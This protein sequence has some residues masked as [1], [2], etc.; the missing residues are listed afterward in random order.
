MALPEKLKRFRPDTLT[1]ILIA[2]IIYIWFRPPAWVKDFNSPAPTFAVS[3]LDGREVT[4]E[5]LKGK[6]VLVSFW[7]TW[8]PYCRHEMPS[9]DEFYQDY[10]NKGFEILALSIDDEPDKVQAF[11][12]ETGYHFPVGMSDPLIS[13]A[14]GGV[15]QVPMSFVIDTEGRIRHKVTGQVHYAR[16]E[17]LVGPLLPKN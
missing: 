17:S 15:S 2:V 12:K 7:A 9:M 3:L 8:C 16:L 1:I 4:L 14:F 6:V 11:M 13:Q 5:S 10:R